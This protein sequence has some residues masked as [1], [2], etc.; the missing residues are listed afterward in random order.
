M[1]R[2]KTRR[3]EEGDGEVWEESLEMR[4]FRVSPCPEEAELAPSWAAAVARDGN[5][6]I[7]AP[8]EAVECTIEGGEEAKTEILA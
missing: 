4:H 6:E 2:K 8:T 1:A 5:D 7:N 3:R